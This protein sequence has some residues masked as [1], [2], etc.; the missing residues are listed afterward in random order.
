MEL[1]D[2]LK[3]ELLQKFFNENNLIKSI[4]NKRY[5]MFYDYNISK[6]QKI[7][8]IKNQEIFIESNSKKHL[9][10]MMD[11]IKTYIVN[12]K[13]KNYPILL[14]NPTKDI[15]KYNIRKEALQKARFSFDEEQ[16]RDIKK[17][18]KNLNKLNEKI[19]FPFKILTLNK[20]HENI[21]YESFKINATTISKNELQEMIETQNIKDTIIISDE[22]IFIELPVYSFKDIL[23]I[24]TGSIIKNNKDTIL[25]LLEL[26]HIIKNYLKEI[27]HSA[28]KLL[29]IDLRINLNEEKI[30]QQLT[31]NPIDE[32]KELTNKTLRLEE[33]TEKLNFELKEIIS[34]KQLS[35]QGDELL[36][37]L[38][39]GD[40]KSLQQ[41]FEKDTKELITKKEKELIEYYKQKKINI[42]TI[43]E[44]NSYPLKILPEIKDELLSK[45]EIKNKETE[46]EIFQ[47]LGEHDYESIIKIYDLAFFFDFLYAI[48]NFSKEYNLLYP[49]I[50]NVE[51]KIIQGRNI[52][53]KN[54]IPIDYAIGSNK[55][56]STNLN[57]E[58]VSVLTGANSGGKTT[59]LEMF[60]QAHILTS[61]G[62]KIPAEE[63][64]QIK[65]VEEVIY[66]KKF[67]GTQGSGAFEQT[68]RNLLEILEK[69]NS[70]LI[71]IDE[72]EA[73]TEPGAAAKILINFLH[74]L[75]KTNTLCISV[76]HLGLEIEEYIK[77]KNIKGI[78]IDGISASGLDENG[79]LVTKHQPEYYS[80]GKST[81]ELI[82]KR[83]LQDE[84]FWKNKSEETKKLLEKIS[85]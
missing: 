44:T 42:D 29:K 57:Y 77:E 23:K 22:S 84:K 49:N 13:S 17:I 60:L 20:A 19:N 73:I 15:N 64:S 30:K 41:K 85:K 14:L 35:L 66:L 61:L 80:L 3:H 8:N 38:N 51:T 69:Q 36:E 34:K 28:S 11:I 24:I 63:S 37:L 53:I 45:I 33:E 83:I 56:N 54:A 7:F 5:Y 2:N 4:Q 40:V 62:L 68:V 18:L 39:S 10:K 26:K 59:L 79:N 72:F 25:N 67:T 12:E 70:K 71:L 55:I 75:T 76:S 48:D 82:L 21:L 27:N 31:T 74:E 46:L 81:P 6:L 52:Y 65:L 16:V 1:S 43:F 47:E 78:R 58:K 50:S 32:I 9:N